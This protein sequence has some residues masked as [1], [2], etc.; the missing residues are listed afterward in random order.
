MSLPATAEPEGYHAE[1]AKGNVRTLAGGE[2]VRFDMEAG[3]L[4]ADAAAQM[5][6]KIEALVKG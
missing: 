3:Y 4:A 6:E 1:L 2:S 5:A